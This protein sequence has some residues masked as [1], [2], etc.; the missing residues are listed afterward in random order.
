MIKKFTV[1]AFVGLAFIFSPG[2]FAKDTIALIIS[3]L[4]NPFFVDMKEGAIERAEQL[5]YELV[6]LDSQNDP[7]KELSNVED[8]LVRGVSVILINPTD[9]DAVSN[10]V[11]F[12]NRADTPIITLDRAANHGDVTVH[13]ASDNVGGGELAGNLIFEMFGGGANVIQLE[14]IAGTSA[15]RERGLGFTSAVETFELNLLSSQP[16]NFNRSMGL[17][18]MENLL[19]SHQQVSAVF[20]QNDEMALGAVSAIKASGKDIA[21]VG[22][23]GTDDGIAAVKRGDMSATVAQQPKLIG[24]MGIDAAHKLVNGQVVEKYIPVPLKLIF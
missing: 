17:D 22:F 3:T 12:A 19:V 13:I 21:V 23:D 2:S 6:V 16:A 9:S 5:G 11:R 20:A 7:A 18:V 10:A 4:N 8:I 1:L 14:G 24:E 15:A